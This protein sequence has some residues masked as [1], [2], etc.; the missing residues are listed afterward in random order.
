MTVGTTLT[1]AG[2]YVPNGSTVAF[3]FNFKVL[4][5]DEIRVFRRASDGTETTLGGYTVTFAGDGGSVTFSTAPSDNGDPLYIVS[6]P[7]FGQ[8][9]TLANQGSFSANV[10]DEG[11]DRAAIRDIY[12]K[13]LTDRAFMVPIGSS[14]VVIPSGAGGVLGVD[15]SGNGVFHPSGEFKGD[16]GGTAMAVGLSI[17]IAGM[18]LTTGAA[19]GFNIFRTDGYAATDDNGQAWYRRMASIEAATNG[20]L[21]SADGVRLGLVKSQPMTPEM[22]GAVGNGVVDDYAALRALA[23]FVNAIGGGIVEWGKGKSYY[24]ARFLGDGVSPALTTSTAYI[25]FKGCVGL[26]LNGN[27]CKISVNGAMTRTSGATASCGALRFTDCKHL[28]VRDFA[29]L[30]GNKQQ[31]TGAKTTTESGVPYGLGLFSCSHVL[32][33][34]VYAHH[35]QTDG[36]VVDASSTL[37]DPTTVVLSVTLA[38]ASTTATVSSTASI[39][40]GDRISGLT[41]VS[42]ALT[43]DTY[44][45][46][47]LNGT[48]FTIYRNGAPFASTASGTAAGASF[49]R[50]RKQA[51]RHITMRECR[52]AFNARQGMT[53]AAIRG[54]LFEDCSFNYTGFTAVNADGA[55]P[56]LTFD[57]YGGHSPQ[58]GMDF[59]PDITEIAGQNSTMLDVRPGEVTFRRCRFV[60]NAGDAMLANKFAVNHSYIVE[61]H[62]DAC[63]FEVPA[64]GGDYVASSLDGTIWDVDKGSITNSTFIMRDKYLLLGVS[65]STSSFKFINNFVSGY[66]S[67]VSAYMVQTRI[68]LGQADRLVEG[69]TFIGLYTAP[70][71]GNDTVFWSL[72]DPAMRLLNNRFWSP[73]AAY[74]LNAATTGDP[75]MM[76]VG[77][78]Q[79]AEATGNRWETDLPVSGTQHY[80]VT[81][82]TTGNYTNERFKGASPGASDT[83]KPG[84]V[85]GSTNTDFAYAHDTTQA[86]SS[87]VRLGSK[88][89]D[90]ASLATA[91]QQSTTVTVTDAVVGD[92][93]DAW[94]DVALSGTRLWAEVTAANTVTVYQRNDTGGAVDV[95]SGNLFASVTRRA[96]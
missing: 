38:N 64:A 37:T 60:G 18:N 78:V 62:W 32:I 12:L 76:R 36:F 93:A 69:N 67:A 33:E 50:G 75:G 42:A 45:G 89:Q 6:E 48:D 17:A 58:A 73:A 7:S 21:L 24:I 96:A 53:L 27:G 86:F 91:T 79:T 28:T 54:G 10:V 3:P 77:L 22:F 95:V 1:E 44:V 61:A 66:N 35:W 88:T 65:N 63:H 2:P 87:K 71:A 14:G 68:G 52:S 74:A 23:G 92:R 34:R 51:S 9:I 84:K 30:N 41:G 46:A 70:K 55:A 80:V 85:V 13:G 11:L 8:Q 19:A 29:E 49:I 59:E 25:E 43:G 94:M 47:I 90:W 26:T 81:Y 4:G 20:E 15:G 31:A 82:G 72:T 5:A 16:P 56:S 40:V 57:V 39:K 83:I